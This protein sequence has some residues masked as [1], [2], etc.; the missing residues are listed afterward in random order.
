MTVLQFPKRCRICCELLPKC[1]CH[2]LEEDILGKAID[3]IDLSKGWKLDE[4]IC[5]I[6]RIINNE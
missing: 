4:F 3:Q 2:E 6:E 1:I 5:E